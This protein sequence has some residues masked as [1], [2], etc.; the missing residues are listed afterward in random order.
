MVWSLGK[1]LD[2]YYY[3]REKPYIIFQRRDGA[4]PQMRDRLLTKY[5]TISFRNNLFTYVNLQDVNSF[6]SNSSSALF[7]GQI[8]FFNFSLIPS[9]F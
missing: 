4:Q 2:P 7:N 6:P 9:I 1:I 8:I 5:E 3:H